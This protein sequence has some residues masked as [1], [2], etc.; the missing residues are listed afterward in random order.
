M[1]VIEFFAMTGQMPTD[2]YMEGILENSPGTQAAYLGDDLL[3]VY[4]VARAT[5]LSAVASP[6]MLATTAAEMPAAQKA[7]ARRS[8]AEA[9]RILSGF[10]RFENYV[11]AENRIVLRWLRWLGFDVSPQTVRINGV[12]FRKFSLEA[13]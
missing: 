9:G 10:R 8:K 3:C 5:V 12:D 4:G 1:D 11:G 2:E 6:W 13:G 7:I